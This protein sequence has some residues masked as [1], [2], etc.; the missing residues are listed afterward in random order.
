MKLQLLKLILAAFAQLFICN[1]G[2][3]QQ[4]GI[5]DIKKRAI[6]KRDSIQ[7]MSAEIFSKNFHF[8]YDKPKE[9]QQ[10]IIKINNNKF[11]FHYESAQSEAGYFIIEIADSVH[12]TDY[13]NL[14]STFSA[15][16]FL[17]KE[18]QGKNRV[19]INRIL[20][21]YLFLEEDNS[22]NKTSLTDTVIFGVPC[23]EI[24]SHESP[25]PISSIRF[26]EFFSKDDSLFRGM[27]QLDLV[28]QTDTIITE[29][30]I[31]NLNLAP[32][33]VL[34]DFNEGLNEI[35]KL[36]SKYTQI[37]VEKFEFDGSKVKNQFTSIHAFNIS[38]QD[39]SEIDLSKGI[40]LLDFWFV[41]CYPC[42]Q[43]IPYIDDLELKY[44]KN[45]LKVIKLNPLDSK[46]LSRVIN[47]SNK[48]K[49]GSQNYVIVR[50]YC[51]EFGVVSYPTFIV[52]KDGHLIKKIEGFNE[53]VYKKI[54]KFISANIK[55]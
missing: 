2:L 45:G 47:Y 6:F 51:H 31:K 20:G 16:S 17:K 7:I 26:S 18:T 41:G 14:N 15:I 23:W 5:N 54:E 27:Y 35:E 24:R 52:I 9:G 4:K 38:H 49:L 29:F 55:K 33:I 11:L 12:F 40:Y 46:S 50:D 25:S 36:K 53:D 43:S 13:S 21:K 10:N 42:L 30:F 44:K 1:L 8:G 37:P 28:E 39:S 48:H 22:S 32:N 19:F 3:A 34:R